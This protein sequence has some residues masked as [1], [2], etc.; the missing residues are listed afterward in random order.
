MDGRE[1]AWNVGSENPCRI[2]PIGANEKEIPRGSQLF[3]GVRHQRP[4][5]VMVLTGVEAVAEHGWKIE[6]V[7][8]LRQLRAR[9]PQDCPYCRKSMSAGVSGWCGSKSRRVHGQK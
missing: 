4:H 8:K 2:G 3:V 7:K 5:T 6:S 1:G 9:T